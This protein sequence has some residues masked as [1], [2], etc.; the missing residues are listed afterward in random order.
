MNAAIATN[1]AAAISPVIEAVSISD[2]TIFGGTSTSIVPYNASNSHGT[3]PTVAY[4]PGANLGGGLPQQNYQD[5]TNNGTNVGTP[6]STTIPGTVIPYQQYGGYGQL[7][8]AFQAAVQPGGTSTIPSLVNLLSTAY[9][10]NSNALGNAKYFFAN[11]TVGSANGITTGSIPV[12]GVTP[13][14]APNGY[15]LPTVTGASGSVYDAYYLSHGYSYNSNLGPNQ[16]G[17]TRPVQFTSNSGPSVNVYDPQAIIGLTTNPA[18]PS[19]HTT[20]AYTD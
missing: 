12:A 13:V 4:G 8:N 3:S 6:G 2:K 10:F 16:Y 20:Y 19:G 5:G 11:G 15:S 18:F 17:D 7:G 14:V 1:N 9:T